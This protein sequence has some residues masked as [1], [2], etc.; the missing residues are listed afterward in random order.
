MVRLR[1]KTHERRERVWHARHSGSGT[2]AWPRC[3][4]GSNEAK[5]NDNGRK[6]GSVPYGNDRVNQTQPNMNPR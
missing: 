6:R 4:F 2:I 5:W 3:P 1:I